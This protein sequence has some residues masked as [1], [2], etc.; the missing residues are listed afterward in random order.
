MNPKTNIYNA[1]TNVWVTKGWMWVGPG[2]Q[3]LGAHIL[4]NF[5]GLHQVQDKSI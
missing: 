1:A 3:I 5:T 4:R 2:L